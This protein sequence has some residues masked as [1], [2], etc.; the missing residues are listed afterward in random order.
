MVNYYYNIDI[1]VPCDAKNFK[2]R[3]YEFPY[4][5]HLLFLAYTCCR[6][7][8]MNVLELFLTFPYNNSFL[9]MTRILLF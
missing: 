2:V 9:R 1:I 4:M 8:R 6:A 3:E 7:E 5:C